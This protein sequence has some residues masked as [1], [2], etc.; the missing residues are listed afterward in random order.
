MLSSPGENRQNEEVAASPDAEGSESLVLQSY[1]CL[2][3]LAVIHLF[4]AD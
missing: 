1:G 4:T 2:S 3:K